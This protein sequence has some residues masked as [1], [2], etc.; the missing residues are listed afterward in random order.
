MKQKQ[1]DSPT[2]S[3]P[4]SEVIELMG[5][6]TATVVS[7][8][9][10]F[11]IALIFGKCLAIGRSAFSY[12]TVADVAANALIISPVVFALL[13]AITLHR[14]S[15]P[16]PVVQSTADDGLKP[17]SR[18]VIIPLLVVWVVAWLFLPPSRYSVAEFGVAT[19][20]IILIFDT[21]RFHARKHSRALTL[22]PFA[23]ICA[24]FATIAQA[25]YFLTSFALLSTPAPSGD[26]T[27]Q[28][29]CLD[30]CLEARV[31]A[32]FSEVTVIKLRQDGKIAFVSNS[33]IKS[34]T[35]SAP[36]HDTPLIDLGF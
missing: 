32:R 6:L 11:G 24:F 34:V 7:I 13:A 8:G 2:S 28:E 15:R 16:D 14:L 12:I 9:L 31:V 1:T 25:S 26:W 22:V 29:I 3:W 30:P 5:G 10:C 19:L 23:A 17:T 35:E 27:G 36:R 4:F 18:L 33:E 20:L 21:V